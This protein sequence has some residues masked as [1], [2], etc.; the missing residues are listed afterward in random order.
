MCTSE[1]ARHSTAEV[2][3]GCSAAASSILMESLFMGHN[4]SSKG[5]AGSLDNV[6][7]EAFDTMNKST[8][9]RCTAA[10]ARRTG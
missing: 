7:T 1:V 8:L 5:D 4:V 3:L 6:H 2:A 9:W 10:F